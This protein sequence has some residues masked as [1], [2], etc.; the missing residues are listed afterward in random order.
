MLH[1]SKFRLATISCA[2]PL[3]LTV[4]ASDAF[5]G[6]TRL[7]SAAVLTVNEDIKNNVADTPGSLPAQQQLDELT[8]QLVQARIRTAEA[9]ARLDWIT[10]ILNDEHL[11]PASDLFG[12]V[13][14]AV[15]NPMII[16]LRR[17]YVEYGAREADWSHRY[18]ADHLAVVSLRNQMREIR[19]AIFDELNRLAETYRSDYEIAKARA[20]ALSQ[21]LEQMSRS[22]R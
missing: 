12:T 15:N 1:S 7:A 2:T 20:D 8:N 13:A 9:K 16:K 10:A 22:S 3:F 14:E 11:D 17:E 19:K 21:S 6:P 5:S 4:C 18:G